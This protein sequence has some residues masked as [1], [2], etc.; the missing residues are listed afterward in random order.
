MRIID[1]IR[2]DVRRFTLCLC[3]ASVLLMLVASVLFSSDSGQKPEWKGTMRTENGVVIV[4]NPAEPLYKSASLKL[5]EELS[6]GGKES[7][8][9]AE[10][11]EI[12]WF[13]ADVDGNIYVLNQ[14]PYDVK[15]F[16]SQGRFI[17]KFGAKGQGPGEF[18]YPKFLYINRDQELEIFEMMPAK[19][20]CYSQDGKYLRDRALDY[21]IDSFLPYHVDEKGF[22][23]GTRLLF[24]PAH[25]TAF[26]TAFVR[27]DPDLKTSK[28]VLQSDVDNID[29][30]TGVVMVRTKIISSGFNGDK[31]VWGYSKEYVLHLDDH[32][33]KKIREIHMKKSPLAITEENRAE[34]T[35]K[36]IEDNPD[37]RGKKFIFPDH[38]PF[39]EAIHF[40]EGNRILV[41]TDE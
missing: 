20:I 9:D 29:L 8:G 40:L 36:Y 21:Q 4:E 24:D 31:V 26:I 23:H 18:Q 15:A 11:T 14:R 13:D 1:C 5:T 19:F 16:D 35:K 33:G 17:R 27:V 12:W 30:L 41:R 28:V 37:S 22:I 38:F 2:R 39:F 32:S 3:G 10:L 34:M 7:T 25:P 6:V